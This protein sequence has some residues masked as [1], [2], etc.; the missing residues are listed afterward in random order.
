MAEEQQ[1][2]QRA[3]EQEIIGR[4]QKAL[5]EALPALSAERLVDLLEFIAVQHSGQNFNPDNTA[6]AIEIAAFCKKHP[7]AVSRSGVAALARLSRHALGSSD[8][9]AQS[10]EHQLWLLASGALNTA[11]A[12]CEHDGDAVAL[13]EAVRLEAATRG[14]YV[15]RLFAHAAMQDHLQNPDK[16][17]L[18]LGDPDV[19]AALRRQLHHLGPWGWAFAGLAL[20]VAVL[21]YVVIASER[22]TAAAVSA[23]SGAGN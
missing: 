11:A 15:Q 17:K 8:G 22:A 12:I 10:A 1:A 7:F 16:F 20:F 5:F 2:K 9:N 23:V 4:V 3:P 18:G 19:G 6:K 13:F 21:A 14:R